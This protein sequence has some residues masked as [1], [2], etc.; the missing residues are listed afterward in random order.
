M[1][2]ARDFRSDREV[3]KNAHLCL[4]RVLRWQAL[5][6]QQG[7]AQIDAA[8]KGGPTKKG[9]ART[10]GLAQSRLPADQQQVGWHEVLFKCLLAMCWK[11]ME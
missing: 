7:A 4:A 8:G 9:G 3:A 1:P 10:T 5:G 11:Q 6:A 2:F